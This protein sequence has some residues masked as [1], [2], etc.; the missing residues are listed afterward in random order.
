MTCETQY[1]AVFKSLFEN[2]DGMLIHSS[3]KRRSTFLFDMSM[4]ISLSAEPLT[5]KG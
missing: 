3:P 5:A 1:C 4:V 2:V